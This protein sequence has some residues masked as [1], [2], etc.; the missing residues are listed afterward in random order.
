MID[1]L[2][3]VPNKE[4]R[5][6]FMCGKCGSL[7]VHAHGAQNKDDLAYLLVCPRCAHV[8]GEWT[9]TEGREGELRDFA[10]RAAAKK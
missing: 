3:A 4:G 5:I 9:T 7:P 8:L 10:K 1:G 6:I 2:V